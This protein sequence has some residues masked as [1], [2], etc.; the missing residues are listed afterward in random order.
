MASTLKSITRIKEE[1]NEDG[2]FKIGFMIAVT[3]DAGV[4]KII[5]VQYGPSSVPVNLADRTTMLT[6][7]ADSGTFVLP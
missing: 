4:E 5:T 6:D 2:T 1:Y 3:V 7:A